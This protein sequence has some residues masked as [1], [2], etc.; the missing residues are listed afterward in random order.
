MRRKTGFHDHP[1]SFGRMRY[2]REPQSHLS[3]FQKI[4]EDQRVR[5]TISC[6]NYNLIVDDYSSLLDELSEYEDLSDS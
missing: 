1:I 3:E 5:Q 6:L 4:D 2:K